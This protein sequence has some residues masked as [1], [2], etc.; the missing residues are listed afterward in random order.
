[1][2]AEHARIVADPR[3]MTGRPTI[4]GTRITVEL[5][6]DELADGMTVDEIVVAHPHL[7][8]EDVRAALRYAADSIRHE[9]ISFAVA[10]SA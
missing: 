3:I 9:D 10:E 7:R 6:L 8:T 4:K 1:M 2:P 5:I